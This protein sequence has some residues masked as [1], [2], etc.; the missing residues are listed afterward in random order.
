VRWSIP[1][2][3]FTIAVAVAAA[4]PATITKACASLSVAS[5]TA[6]HPTWG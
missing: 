2:A 1:V 5:I 3:L 4:E 6:F